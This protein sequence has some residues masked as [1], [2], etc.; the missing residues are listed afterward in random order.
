MDPPKSLR[1]AS[2]VV[3]LGFLLLDVAD[4][5]KTSLFVRRIDN[6]VDMPL[7]SD[8]FAIPPGYNAPQQV[9]L[10]FMLFLL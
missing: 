6:N 10:S 4:C 9:L 7:E 8:V 3:V 5:G 1:F 2:I